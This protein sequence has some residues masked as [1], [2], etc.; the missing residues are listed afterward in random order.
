MWGIPH[1]ASR[2]DGGPW[3]SGDGP[4]ATDRQSWR[5]YLF[6]CASQKASIA[7]VAP[8]EGSSRLFGLLAEGLDSEVA[9]GLALLA[10]AGLTQG[11]QGERQI[12]LGG[13]PKHVENPKI[14]TCSSGS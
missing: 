5:A 1:Q 12:Q 8:R 13:V 14:R 10:G 11:D 3:R 6:P 4:S 2:D 9:L 7:S